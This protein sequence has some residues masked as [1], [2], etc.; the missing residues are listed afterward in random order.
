MLRIYEL[1][2]TVVLN[3]LQLFVKFGDK[4]RGAA[5]VIVGVV[6]AE[7]KR[8]MEIDRLNGYVKRACLICSRPCW[9]R[10]RG[11]FRSSISASPRLFVSNQP[12]SLSLL[13]TPRSSLPTFLSL[14]PARRLPL[15]RPLQQRT[16]TFV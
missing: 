12:V 8:Q 2:M 10:L 13:V 9:A 4:A 14:L 11:S 5:I 7:R 15:L 16:P 6:A 3:V 1:L